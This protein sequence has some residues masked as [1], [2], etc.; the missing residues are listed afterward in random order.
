MLRLHAITLIRCCFLKCNSKTKLSRKKKNK[1]NIT[2]Y[3]STCFEMNIFSTYWQFSTRIAASIQV[4]RVSLSMPKHITWFSGTLQTNVQL[5]KVGLL[6]VI[7]G[8][9][10]SNLNTSFQGVVFRLTKLWSW[11]LKGVALAILPRDLSNFIGPEEWLFLLRVFLLQ[12]GFSVNY[13]QQYHS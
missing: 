7:L 6:F 11:Y 13:T 5:F 9:R 2:Q 8:G 1:K 4:L 3:I 10:I 12:K